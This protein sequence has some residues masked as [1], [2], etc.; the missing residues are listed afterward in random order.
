ML[1]SGVTFVFF[2]TIYFSH[3]K[4]LTLPFHAYGPGVHDFK[5]SLTGG[6]VLQRTSSHIIF[7]APED[8]WNSEIEIIPSKV[9]RINK[10]NEFIIAER[11]GLKK[12]SPN[13]C[14]DSYEIPNEKIQDYWILDTDKNYAYKNLSFNEFCKMKKLLKIPNNVQLVDIYEF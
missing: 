8:G 14:L 4:S 7:V 9:I 11:Q 10:Y 5:K 12:R 3:L 13:D 1:F 2:F 6:Y